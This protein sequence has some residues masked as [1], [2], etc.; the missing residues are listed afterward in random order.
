MADFCCG[1]G[2]YSAASF[3]LG[4]KQVFSF[5]VDPAALASCKASMEELEDETC[6]IAVEQVDLT[7][8]SAMA[9][10]KGMFDTV[11]MNP[12]F[13]TK[14]DEGIDM[15]LLRT[16]VDVWPEIPT[17]CS[18]AAATCTRCIRV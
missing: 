6:K 14:G 8:A 18:A 16:A 9:K 1:T 10:Y 15:K 13:G 17:I 3:F 5:D 4:A 11:V 2:L 12:P 7:D